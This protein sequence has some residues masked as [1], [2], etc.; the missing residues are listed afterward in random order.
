LTTEGLPIIS[1][2]KRKGHD[3]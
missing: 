2:R 3:D 1:G